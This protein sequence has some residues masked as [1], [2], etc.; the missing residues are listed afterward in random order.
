MPRSR[1][2]LQ[3]LFEEPIVEQTELDPGFE[4]HGSSVFRVH[5]AGEQ[6]V[7][8]AFRAE[9]RGGPFWS[10]LTALF[11][12][13]PMCAAEAVPIYALLRSASPIP[14]PRLHRVGTIGGRTWLVVE[15]MP[16]TAPATFDELSD[17]GLVEFGRALASIHRRRFAAFGN[18]SGS[19]RH[20]LEE[21][22][23]RLAAALLETAAAHCDEPT[24]AL[25]QGTSAAI[26]ALAP[27]TEATLVLPDLFAPQFLAQDGRIVALVD[28]DAY[29]VGPRELD[30]VCLEYFVDGR[31]APLIARGYGEIAELP[32]LASVRPGYRTF[33]WVLTMNPM[34]LDLE[35]WMSWPTA[36]A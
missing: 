35:R 18:P 31:T 6:V 12:I 28:V 9:G 24:S 21:F 36:F 26:A 20:A 29:V 15:H 5:T 30:L 33:F 16:G 13:D 7:V 32:S 10:C 14:V 11:G 17:D 19:V 34:A 25:V 1:P 27:P 3:A 2:D 8:R 22:H 23:P 4:D